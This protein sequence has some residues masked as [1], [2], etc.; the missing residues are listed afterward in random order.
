MSQET[1]MPSKRYRSLVLLLLTIIYAFNFIDRQIIGIL[2]PFIQADLGLSNSQLGLL[3]GFLFALFYTVVGLPIAWLA[4]RYSRV[5][6]VAISL[7]TWSAFTALTGMANSF[8]TIGLARMG[9][10]VG[11]AGGSPPSHSMISD[12]YPKE[13][14]AGALAFYSL[15]I[16]MGLGFAYLMTGILLGNPESAMSWRTLLIILGVTGI[17]LAVIMRIIVREPK[18]GQQEKAKEDAI[19]IPFG[20]A[21]KTLLTIPSWWAM[22]LGIAFASFVG[23]AVSTWQMDYL[24]PFD[25]SQESPVGFQNMMYF[26]AFAN[27]VIYGAG[28]YF[29]G[30]LTQ[31]LAVR[32]LAY[33]GLVPAIS[34]LICLPLVIGAFW[35][36]GTWAH[37]F[38]AGSLLFFLGMYLGPSFAIA[39]TLAPINMRAMSTAIFFLVLNLIALGGGPTTV[40]FLAD[41]FK[42]AHGQVHAVRLSI[43]IV[44]VMLVVSSI[45]FFMA[46]KT[47]PKDWAEAQARNEAP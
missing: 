15:G 33:Y 5:N 36:P 42:E 3:K 46:S 35:V 47:L 25:G 20:V 1:D 10:G 9:V 28:T 19:K 11:E 27:C 37:L 41:M 29:G 12:L 8:L 18:R 7:A 17:V 6:I 32:S 26:L 16:P 43:T 40:G 14:R 38:V 31:K 39:Q 21:L 24:L 30:W 4:D 44:S 22:C 45:C 23:Y 13:E 2:S 34:I